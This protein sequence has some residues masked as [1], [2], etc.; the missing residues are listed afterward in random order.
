MSTDATSANLADR[1]VASVSQA[2][3]ARTTPALLRAL[4][5]LLVR[6]EPVTV[7]QLAAAAGQ[8]I[9]DVRRAV[10]RLR[11]GHEFRPAPRKPLED[12]VAVNGWDGLS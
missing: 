3:S 2:G 4:L 7:A 12:V 8:P 5:R 6:G 11:A 9:G 1:L 10:A